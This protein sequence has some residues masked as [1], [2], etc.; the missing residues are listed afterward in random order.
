M[1]VRQLSHKDCPAI[2]DLETQ[3]FDSRFDAEHLRSLLRKP[4]FYGAVLT[5]TGAA[6]DV[7]AYCLSY[8]TS[9]NADIIAIGTHGNWQ[10]CGL[11]QTMLRHMIEIMEQ[12]HVEKIFLEVAVDNFAARQLYCSFGFIEVGSRKNYY[13]RGKARCDALIMARKRVSA[14]A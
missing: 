11:G 14:F 1:E 3:L 5:A 13:Q 4:A 2:A 9:H 10:R 7:H 8:I 12:R 6:S